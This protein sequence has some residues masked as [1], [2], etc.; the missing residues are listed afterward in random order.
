MSSKMQKVGN[1]TFRIVASNVDMGFVWKDG[2]LYLTLNNLMLTDGDIWYEIPIKDLQNIENRE[3][4][5]SFEVESMSLTIKGKNAERL[6]AL[7]HLLLPLIEGEGGGEELAESIVKLMLLGIKDE[8]IMASV[9]KVDE[10]EIRD[11]LKKAEENGLIHGKDVTEKGKSLLS[12]EEIE[13]LEDA[14]MEE[15]QRE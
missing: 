11:G 2:A 9:L 7:R 12:P 13:L 4:T 8:K 6:L 5:L 15:V 14:A 10:D 3:G 1:V